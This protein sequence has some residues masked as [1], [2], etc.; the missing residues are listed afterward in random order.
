MR[1][2]I[3]LGGSALV[4]FAVAVQVSDP[5]DR[6]ASAAV[7]AYDL[8]GLALRSSVIA[9][10]EV[11]ALRSFRGPYLDLG[12]V[13]FTDVTLEITAWWKGTPATGGSSSTG[14][15]TLRV[16]GGQIGT[17]RQLCPDS[18]R[19]AVGERV[20]V[21]LREYQGALWNTGWF[22]GKYALADDGATVLGVPGRPVPTDLPLL[23]LEVAVRE[24]LRGTSPVGSS[25]VLSPARVELE[26]KSLGGS[27]AARS[28]GGTEP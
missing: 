24:I 19:Y 27:A 13:V 10:G 6:E 16:L 4:L 8:E 14:Q 2:R 7:V 9:T 1:V 18:A 26:S 15:M 23:A 3:V 11:T 25:S 22:Q 17:A 12:E 5:G 21:F 28:P 20:L